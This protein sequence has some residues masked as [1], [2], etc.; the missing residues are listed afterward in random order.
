MFKCLEVTFHSFFHLKKVV[1]PEIH[2]VFLCCDCM[3]MMTRI[4]KSLKK[5]N[6]SKLG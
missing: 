4:A 3:I 5:K 6:I 2:F 1:T